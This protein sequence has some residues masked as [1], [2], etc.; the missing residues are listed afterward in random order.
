MIRT[1]L[2]LFL[3]FAF[4]V[5][6]EHVQ[7]LI[8]IPSRDRY[9]KFFYALNKYYENLSGKCTYHFV[10]TLDQDDPTMNCEKVRQILN[11][12]PHLSYYYGNSKTKIEAINK[13]IDKHLNFDILIAT[14][15]DMI[16]IYYGFDL[17][18]LESMHQYFPDGDG[19]LHFNDGFQGKNMNTLPIMGKKYYSRFNYVYHPSYKSFF[20]D[21]EF[22]LI[23]I[24]L[25]KEIYIN[26][27]LIEHNH[28]AW[29]KADKDALFERNLK[30]YNEDR[31]NYYRRADKNFNL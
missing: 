7:L 14:S 21:N 25:K 22:M 12:Y 8:K 5:F 20:C 23:S 19:V 31:D 4:N 16:P 11:T 28:P 1:F 24:K 27:I 26:S 9:E 30:Y 2:L 3:V 29:H 10:I 18:I 13:D 6:A 15:D 17:V